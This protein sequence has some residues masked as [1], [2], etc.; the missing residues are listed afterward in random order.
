M[1][2]PA[3]ATWDFSAVESA[4]MEIDGTVVGT[5]PVGT[6]GKTVTFAAPTTQADLKASFLGGAGFKV[7]FNGKMKNATTAATLTGK[8]FTKLTFN[9]GS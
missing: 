5:M 1:T 4:T 6:T 9:L 7:K 3:A 2:I 8:I